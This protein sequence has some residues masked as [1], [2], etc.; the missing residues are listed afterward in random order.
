MAYRGIIF[1]GTPSD[2]QNFI[3]ALIVSL[4][5]R[6]KYSVV[7][8]RP[9][10]GDRGHNFYIEEDDIRAQPVLTHS[11]GQGKATVF[12]IVALEEDDETGE[13]FPPDKYER[14]LRR[15]EEFAAPIAARFNVSV[16]DE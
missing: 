16:K 3:F 5:D 14:A 2:V 8:D 11:A 1:N 4:P 6:W 15:F 13:A 10:R 7:R 9:A 12:Q